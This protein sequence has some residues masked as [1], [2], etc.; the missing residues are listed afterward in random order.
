MFDENNREKDEILNEITD[1]YIVDET[2]ETSYEYESPELITE[3]SKPRS[4][5]SKIF[6]W[7]SGILVFCLAFSTM[8]AVNEFKRDKDDTIIHQSN[9]NK[10]ENINVSSGQFIPNGNELTTQ[11]IAAKVGPAVVGIVANINTITFFGQQAVTPASGSGVIINKDGYIVTNYH[12]IENG[13]NIKVILNTGKEYEAKII[14]F[15]A[16]SD[17]A[18]LKIDENE[19]V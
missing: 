7:V 2:N 3:E 14:G 15:D 19:L 17:L 16:Q 9:I 8:F 6:A 4:G 11:E 1:E 10:S 5:K 18:V 13:S 12:V